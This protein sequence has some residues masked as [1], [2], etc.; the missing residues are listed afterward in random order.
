MRL[1]AFNLPSIAKLTMTDELHLQELGERKIALFCCIPDS[2][3][4]LNYLVGMIYTQLIQT[5]YRQADR[6]H[7]GRLPVP[8]HCLMDEYANISLPKDTFLS[9]LATMRSRAIFCSIIVQNMAQ[10]KAMYKDDWESLVGLCDE[11]LYLGGTEKETHKYVSELL[12]KETISTT[13]YNQ[14]KGRSGSYSINHQQSGRDLMT[15]DEVRL[16]DNSKC[17]LFIRGERPV[18]DLKY[19][20]LKHPNIRYTEDGGAAP[21][22]YTAAD[23]ARDDLPGAPE[24]YELL[25]IDILPVPT[26]EAARQLQST[27]LGV[28]TNVANWQR[29]QNANN[30][31]TATIPYDMELQ[32]K[33]TKEML[34]DLTTRDQ[35][36]M[37]G[38]VTL[39][40][41][42]DSKE[43]LDSDTET[44]YSTAR[45]HLCQLS[46]LRWQQKDG[47]DT[48][49]PYGLR[50]I[51][52]LRT[53]TTESTAVLIPFRAQEIMEPNGLYYGQNAVSKNMIVADR[54]L[55]LNGNSFRLGVSGSGKSM[56]AKEEIVQIALST[57]DDIL[58]LDPESEFGYL[59]EAL[60]GEVIRISATSD[61]HINALD[62]DRAYGDERNPIVSKSEFVLSLFEQLIGDGMVTAKEKSILG[63]CTEQV[64]LPYIRNGYKGTPPTLQ[65]F[66][67]LL[68]MQPEPE[69]QGLALSSELFITGTL[70]TFARHTNVDTQARIIAYDIRELGEQLMPLGMLVTLDAIYNRVIQNWKKGRRTWI[71]CDEFYI[72]FRYEYSANFFYKL[73]KRIRKYNGLVTGLTQ[74]VDELLHSDT[75]RLMLANSEFLV[76]LNQSATD[77]AE[78]AKLL[79][80]SDNQLGYV[81][82]V[83]A[84]CGLIRCAGN[85]VPFT[86][87]FPKDTKL[88][89]LMSTNP[90]EKR[91]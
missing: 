79:N 67:R 87:S 15:P 50:K 33:E 36:M 86:N 22:D 18:I 49:L 53:L 83:P 64:Y 70:N 88:Y 23:N 84:G 72:L 89:K 78:L 35:R 6:V 55:L 24:N 47:L 25:D 21:Y 77:R 44:L 80:I 14:S 40:H 43:Q 65:D 60:G 75:A 5:L 54:R 69:A 41:L 66:Y 20:L 17:I 42:A 46:T 59:T 56:S 39:V 90:S 62:M 57:E 16:L 30:N 10:L 31:F 52:A 7:K 81:T 13:S 38:L 28:E 2:D 76:M 48:V 73:W 19:N 82:N 58:I 45:K 12:G 61:T 63:R 34:D 29:R 26:D 37:F 27:L 85:I 68:Q 91:E 74:N 1:A 8:V 71:F 32:R 3:K 11:F 4:S 9:A 51:Q